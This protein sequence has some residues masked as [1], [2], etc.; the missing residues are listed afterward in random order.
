MS[1]IFVGLDPSAGPSK[2][3]GICLLNETK[4]IEYLGH[5]NHQEEILEILMSVSGKPS[6]IGID[7]PLRL[8]HELDLCCFTELNS[9]C[10]HKQTTPYKGR[11]CEYLLIK[12]G[13]RCFLTS[14]N[15]FVKSWVRRCLALQNFLRHHL[16]ET[17]EVFPYATRRILFPHI[18]GKK[19]SLPFRENLLQSLIDW[20]IQFSGKAGCFSHDELDALLAAVT[21]YLHHQ[22]QIEMIGDDRDGYIVIPK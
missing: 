22:N 15:S 7:G 19:H 3:S 16:F 8:P 20:G 5:W 18:T 9:Q 17:I 1:N 6:I 10:D 4:K 2:S 11:Y 14:K 21:V 12:K 13:Y